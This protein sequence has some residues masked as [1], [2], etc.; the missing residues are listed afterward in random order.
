[1]VGFSTTSE[2][3]DQHSGATIGALGAAMAGERDLTSVTKADLIAAL[4]PDADIPEGAERVVCSKRGNPGD[5]GWLAQPGKNGAP[6]SCDANNYLLPATFYPHDGKLSA[7]KDHAAAVHFVMF[8]DIGTKGSLSFFRNIKQTACVETSPGNYQVMIAL[9]E[10]IT[11]FAAVDRLQRAII[12][13]CGSDAAATGARTRWSRLHASINGKPE[14]LD[15]DGQPFRT[16]LVEFNPD[17]RYSIVEIAERTGVAIDAQADERPLSERARATEPHSEREVG[18]PATAAAGESRTYSSSDYGPRDKARARAALEDEIR[19]LEGV[20]SLRNNALNTAACKLGKFIGDAGLDYADVYDA[21]LGAARTNGYVAKRGEKR[22]GDT[23]ESGLTAGMAKPAPPLPEP[24]PVSPEIAAMCERLANG[25]ADAVEDID[26]DAIMREEEAKKANQSQQLDYADLVLGHEGLVPDL[27]K[28]ILEHALIPHKRFAVAAALAVVAVAASRQIRTPRDGD[29]NLFLVLIADT[30]NGKN[31]PLQ[32]VKNILTQAGLP[33]LIGPAGASSD[34]ALYEFARMKPAHCQ[35]IDELGDVL[36]ALTSRN[37][38]PFQMKVMKALRELWTGGI[39]TVPGS[40]IRI[41][42]T[43]L[44]HPCMSIIAGT[45]PG[46]FYD[47]ISA[48]HQGDGTLNRMLAIN[49]GNI[50]EFAKAP[51]SWRDFPAELLDRVVEVANLPNALNHAFYRVS[52]DDAVRSIE[53]DRVVKWGEG[54]EQKWLSY[55]EHCRAQFAYDDSRKNLGARTPENALR[56]A[57]VLAVGVDR[58]EPIVT[59]EQIEIGIAIAEAS[60][61]DMTRG[62]A[63]HVPVSSQLNLAD[64]VLEIINDAPGKVMRHREV[65]RKLWRINSTAR[66]RKEAIDALLEVGK[67]SRVNFKGR[68]G[69]EAAGYKIVEG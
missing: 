63:T 53:P 67:I 30:A 19:K 32:A 31:T 52:Q 41:N 10:P 34:V 11:D 40:L 58:Y 68:R 66:E 65:F 36:S 3:R 61:A 64:K 23:I 1:M 35:V 44:V 42:E 2:H 5:G 46:Q 38:S 22:A 17:A 37:A 7:K 15:A 8:D 55:I 25:G 39:V 33:E 48:K 56:L 29:L 27:A 57:C 28:A 43:P 24:D 6:L 60:F 50:G 18:T 4:I 26:F 13:A 59:A 54:A 9:K 14:Y 20:T 49:V 21:L 12:A 16:R 47:G 51:K 69:P 45:T 62:I